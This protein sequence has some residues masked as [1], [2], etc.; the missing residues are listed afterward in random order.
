[1]GEASKNKNKQNVRIAPTFWLRCLKWFCPWELH[2]SIEGDL[3]E[4]YEE[5]LKVFSIR[6][7]KIRLAVNVIRF[8][9]PG[10]LLR[11]KFSITI[12]QWSMLKNYFKVAFRNLARNRTYSMVSLA[13][14]TLG[15]TVAL[16]LVL[17]VR[18]ENS[19]D[20]YH[21]RAKNIYQ[22]KAYDKF[23]E[24]QTHAPQGAVK[25]LREEI[26]GVEIAANVYRW[27][28]QVIRVNDKVLKQENAFFLH[29]EFLTMID[30]E[31][32]FGSAETSLQKPYQVVLDEPTAK[33]LFGPEDPI[34][35][36][37]RYDNVMDLQVSGLIAKVPVNSEFQFQMIM[38]YQTL[39][40][41]RHDFQNDD[42]WGGG[43]SWFHGYVLVNEQADIPAIEKQLS[44]MVAEHKDYNTYASFRLLPLAEKHFDMDSDPFN[45]VTPYW[46]VQVLITIAIF[47]IAIACINFINLST[48][49]AS[50]RGREIGVRKVLGSNRISII[51]QFF[52]ESGV[53]V[54]LSA[55]LASGFAMLL[56]PYADLLFNSTVS[57]SEIWSPTLIAPLVAIVLIVTLL[58]GFYP[59]MLLSGLKPVA[60]FKNQFSSLFGKNISLRKSLVVVQFVIAQVLIICM[61]IGMEQVMFFSQTDLG[62]DKNNVIT[63]SMPY[64]DSVLLQERFK[65]QLSQH[66]EIQNIT[67]GL[68]SPSSNRNWWWGG[69]KHSGLLNGEATFRLQWVDH[70]YFE[71]YNI[72][73]LAGR[74]FLQ[75]DTSQLVLVN[76]KALRDMG[77]DKPE[78]A[79]D[80]S[81]VFWGDN[82]ATIVGVVK[83]Y[84]SQGLKTEVPPHLYLYGNWNFQLAQIKINPS[85]AASAIPVIEKYWKQLHP[86][87]YFEYEYLSEALNNF[88]EDENKL[89]NFIILFAA[90]GI[91]IGCLGLF[92]LVSF[93]C[94]K[95][96]KEISVRKVFGA[97]VSNIISLLSRDFILLVFIALLIAIPIGWYV[98]DKFLQNYENH[99]D[100]QL[101]VFVTAGVI[102]LAFA[103]ITVCAR[104]FSTA[105]QNPS[106]T[107]RSE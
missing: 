101:S 15:L 77:F 102:T 59:A 48:A 20:S 87:H 46:I 58:A 67:Y 104:A 17:I 19:F 12:I 71:F 53:M 14:L 65:Q 85:H 84:H 41:Y 81:L 31:W 27:D 23:G 9:R 52:A 25:A 90:V 2:E 106:L 1:M 49:Q 107:L 74:N 97:T 75:Q 91:I 18:F 96:A 56:I 21:P 60:I 8:I 4:Q 34:G 7:A 94:S 62:F 30:I 32:K 98:M 89:F 16:V 95:R 6:G 28:P 93:V 66:P 38:S 72:P 76:E 36:T 68:T 40:K 37:I 63:V 13:G 70:N 86:D 43:D 22:V 80:Q 57:Q 3:L 5:H 83:N 73:L 99:I 39:A 69:V 35:K 78:E 82:T 88:Y 54:A 42:H 105:M 47:I 44:T 92:G 51:V 100:I 55:F 61:I 29:P 50:T 33:K 26:A 64:R 103:L 10:I 11:N 45:Y 24:P 79:L